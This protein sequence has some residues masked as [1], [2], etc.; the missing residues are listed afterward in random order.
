MITD[1]QLASMQ[2]D[3]ESSLYDTCTRRRHATGAADTFGN[4]AAGAASDVTYDC[5]LVPATGSEDTLDR[6]VQTKEGSFLL[7]HDADVIGGDQIIHDAVTWEVI[8][9]A[10][11]QSW[12]THLRV[13]VRRTDAI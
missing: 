11:A 10:V 3:I 4:P 2:A 8:G 12:T 1:E 7:P 9:P 6:D 13:L 5:R